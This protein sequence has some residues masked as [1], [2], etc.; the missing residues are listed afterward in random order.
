[1]R[2]YGEHHL[3]RPRTSTFKGETKWVDQLIKNTLVTEPV[4]S[5]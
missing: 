2:T 3:R 4:K 1:M 5:K